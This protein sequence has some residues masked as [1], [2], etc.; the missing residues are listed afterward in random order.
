MNTIVLGYD[1]SPSANAALAHLIELAPRLDATVHVVFGYYISPLGGGEMKELHKAL[2]RVGEHELGRARADLEA[3]RIP[4]ETHLRSGKPADA[5]LE[6]ADEID[7]GLVV[8]GTR[9]EGPIT[10]AVLGSVVLKLVQRSRRP[11]LVVPGD[12]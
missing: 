6:V 4:V 7:A 1:G 11:M 9:G 3:A 8:V 10:G 12:E 2:V 5:I